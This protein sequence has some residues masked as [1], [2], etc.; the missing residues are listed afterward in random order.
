MYLWFTSVARHSWWS[1]RSICSNAV[2]TLPRPHPHTPYPPFHVNHIWSPQLINRSPY[3]NWYQYFS[4]VATRN[5]NIEPAINWRSSALS[6]FPIWRLVAG[7][8][9][10]FITVYFTNPMMVLD[11]IVTADYIAY[12]SAVT[13]CNSI[14]LVPRGDWNIK[15]WRYQLV[16]RTAM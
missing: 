9:H 2:S 14:I 13:Y 1:N 12:P 3:Y 8:L 10:I 5:I 4:I 11:F 15:L 7:Q 16:Y 6:L